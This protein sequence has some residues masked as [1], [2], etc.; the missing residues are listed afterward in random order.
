VNALP[1]QATFYA[2]GGGYY[3]TTSYH[4]TIWLPSG[5]RTTLQSAM[6]GPMGA[7]LTTSTMLA[8]QNFP[9]YTLDAS[10]SLVRTAMSCTITAAMHADG[11]AYLTQAC[12]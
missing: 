5:G 11:Y 4:Q 3:A 10:V 12:Q 1:V 8:A 7:T 2:D 6:S 9:H